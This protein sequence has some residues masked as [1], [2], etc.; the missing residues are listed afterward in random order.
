MSNFFSTYCPNQDSLTICRSLVFIV[1]VLKID[2]LSFTILIDHPATD[3]EQLHY[4]VLFTVSL[5][6]ALSSRKKFK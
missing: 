1:N 3:Y 2:N 4:F 6:S 5:C